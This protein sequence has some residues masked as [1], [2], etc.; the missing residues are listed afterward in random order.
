[1]PFMTFSLEF[2]CLLGI[3]LNYFSESIMLKYIYKKTEDIQ[4]QNLIVI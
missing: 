2:L 1:M 4:P 3:M